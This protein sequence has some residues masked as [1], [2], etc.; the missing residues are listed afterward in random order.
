MSLTFCGKYA[1]AIVY[2][3]EIE[4]GAVTQ[5][6]GFLNHSAF[7]GMTIRIM[8]DCHAGKGAVIGFTSTLSDK[9]IPN[10][11]GVDIACGVATVELGKVDVKPYHYPDLDAFIR[12]NI[13]SGRNVR[14]K[15]V[16]RDILDRTYKRVRHQL[17][18][19]FLADECLE[20]FEAVAD[21]TDQRHSYIRNSLGTLGGG[22]HFLELGEDEEGIKYFTVHTGSRNFG[23]KIALHHQDKAKKIKNYG[24]LSYL[25]GDDAKAYLHDMQIAQIYSVWNRQIILELVTRFFFNMDA[26]SYIESMHNFI[27]MKNGVIRKGAVSAQLDELVVIPWNMRDGLIIGRGKGNADWNFSA[28]HGAGRNL[29]RT[30]AKRDL[31]LDDFKATMANVWTSCVGKDTL[32]ESP[33]AYKDAKTIEDYMAPTVEVLKRVRPL[34]S[35]KDSKE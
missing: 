8:P 25:E 13:P 19:D 2:T 26:V 10:V 20:K 17:R 30:V 14:D 3:D 28:P 16:S 22:N 31:S 4:E 1:E 21:T 6:Y 29:S 5:I 9:I 18:L 27:D 23:L 32:D 34:Y 12:S 35:Y 15:M 33:M 7:D 11:I 24:D